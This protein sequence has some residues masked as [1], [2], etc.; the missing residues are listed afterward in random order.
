M[1]LFVANIDHE[2]YS[3]Y[4]NSRDGSFKD[5]AAPNGIALATWLMSGWGVKFFD[6][7]NDGNLDLLLANGNPDDTIQEHFKD[8]HYEEPLLLFRNTGAGFE[9]ALENVS[10][11]AGPIF[12]QP[13][14]AR[15]MAIGDYDNDG[16]VDVLVA[17]N[18]GAPLLLHNVTSAGNHW[19]GIRLIGKKANRDAVGAQITYKA[20][21]LTR[22]QF[23]GGGG[24]YLAS[25]DPRMVLGLGVRT[26]IDWV[27]VKWPQPS[28]LVERFTNLPTDRYITLEEGSGKAVSKA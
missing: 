27:E 19:L 7:D 9:H 4:H 23:K 28:G 24:S 6:F 20:G 10:G 8:V 17:V 16:A 2:K 11:A 26:Q 14:A 1:D 15:G 18:S 25:H 3:L 21:D 5:A 22:R 12:Q 13:F